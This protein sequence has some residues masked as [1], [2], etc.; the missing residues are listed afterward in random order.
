MKAN[1]NVEKGLSNNSDGSQHIL[2]KHFIRSFIAVKLD[3]LVQ[4]VLNIQ[5]N[6]VRVF[7]PHPKLKYGTTKCGTIL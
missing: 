3:V 4:R 2:L 1:Q 5:L 7:A 6:I